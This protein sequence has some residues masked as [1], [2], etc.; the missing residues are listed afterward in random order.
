[1]NNLT[2]TKAK[3]LIARDLKSVQNTRVLELILEILGYGNKVMEEYKTPR[4]VL[5]KFVKNYGGTMYYEMEKGFEIAEK[6]MDAWYKSK[7]PSAKE[8]YDLISIPDGHLYSMN[9]KIMSEELAQAIHRLFDF[10]KGDKNE[11]A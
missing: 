2:I 10:H 7:V 1:M 11:K 6:E 4:E 3:E 8:I 5:E 9:L